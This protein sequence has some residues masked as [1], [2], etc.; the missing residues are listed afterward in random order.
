MA[1][2][3]LKQD[4]IEVNINGRSSQAY[5]SSGSMARRPTVTIIHIKEKH[6]PLRAAVPCMPL[7]I[8]II[9]CL[10]NICT[11]GI[12]TLISAFTVFCCGKTGNPER[13]P[14]VD[15]WLNILSALLQII[16]FPVIVGWIW[17]IFWGMTFVTLSAEYKRARELQKKRRQRTDSRG[18]SQSAE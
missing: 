6:G 4:S 9:C 11:P 2:P 12:G 8:A 16:T 17:S 1:S 7:P 15:F 13:A 3:A 18:A 10:L 5:I 14:C